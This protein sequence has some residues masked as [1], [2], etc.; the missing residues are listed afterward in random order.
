MHNSCQIVF[1]VKFSWQIF[2]KSSIIK[3]HESLASGAE[4]FHTNRQDMHKKAPHV[5]KICDLVSVTNHVS[6]FRKIW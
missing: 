6:E 4:L 5:E 1:K 3:F 2:K